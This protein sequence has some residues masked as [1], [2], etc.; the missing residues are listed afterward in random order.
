MVEDLLV[1][2][3]L[4]NTV[5][6][7]L[8]FDTTAKAIANDP[9]TDLPN[10]YQV[11][12]VS[13]QTIYARVHNRNAPNACYAITNFTLEVTSEPE[14][15][16][17]TV[18]R[19]CDDIAS[20]SDTILL[21]SEIAFNKNLVF[22]GLYNTT[23]TLFVSGNNTTRIFNVNLS[24]SAGKNLVLDSMV[25]VNG[26]ATT[27]DDGGAVKFIDGD[28]LFIG[29]DWQFAA[30]SYPDTLMTVEGCDSIIITDLT[31]N[32]I[33]SEIQPMCDTVSCQS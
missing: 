15:V 30:G 6:T 16:Q 27:T 19:L 26:N 32:P 10:P 9:N 13:S 14:P 25:L 11:N 12:T 21:T 3:G 7:V 4:D 18:Y 22:K 20:G 1:K 24:S 5:F 17:P 2:Y 29:G 28:S 33:F 31:I 23:D 8:Y